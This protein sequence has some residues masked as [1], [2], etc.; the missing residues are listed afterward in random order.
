MILFSPLQHLH[1]DIPK[2]SDSKIVINAETLQRVF[3]AISEKKQL[4]FIRID[5]RPTVD[6]STSGEE[7]EQLQDSF[8]QLLESLS[9]DLY[10]FSLNLGFKGEGESKKDIGVNIFSSLPKFIVKH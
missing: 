7:L 6:E 8:K 2:P 10:F 5:L 9:S 4:E 3:L 1:L